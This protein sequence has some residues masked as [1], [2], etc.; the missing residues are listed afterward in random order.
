VTSDVYLGSMM[1]LS[2]WPGIDYMAGGTSIPTPTRRLFID[3]SGHSVN[4]IA[5][6]GLIDTWG[7]PPIFL[8]GNAAN[9]PNNAIGT[10][11]AFT[12]AAGGLL[13]DLVL[14]L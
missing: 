1:D 4:P 6:G 14:P 11:G 13:D 9:F 7:R 10:A 5:P 12:V 8:S 2:I 3:G